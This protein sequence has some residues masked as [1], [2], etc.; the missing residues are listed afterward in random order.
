MAMRGDIDGLIDAIKD[1]TGFTVDNYMIVDL[2]AFVALVDAIDG[3]EFDIPI[4][5]NYDD[6]V[7]D[8]HIHFSAG[9]TYLYGEDAVKVVRFRQN[10]DGTGYPRAD[11]DRIATQQA[12]LKT[13]MEKCLKL[14]SLITNIDDYAN[15]FMTYVDT[16]LTLGNLVW[17]GQQVLGIG[18]ENINFHTLPENYNDSIRGGS[19]CSILID[20][21]LELLNSSFNPFDEPITESNLNILTRDEDGNLYSTTGTIAG[22]YDSFYNY[23]GYEDEPDPPEETDYYEEPDPPEETDYYE[24]PDPPEE[25][26]DIPSNPD[27]SWP[28]TEDN[29]SNFNTPEIDV[30]EIDVPEIDVPVETEPGYSN[31]G[32]ESGTENL[33]RPIIIG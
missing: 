14:D 24:E 22:G 32:T 31:P 7:Q 19:Y 29:G 13:V 30:P 3:V 10:N 11:I 18:L 9:T 33:D 1:I 17:Y 6:P 16:D 15:I 20:E 12:F 23:Y 2:E 26:E 28:G 27:Q 8:L 4:D 25:T 21:W 5:M